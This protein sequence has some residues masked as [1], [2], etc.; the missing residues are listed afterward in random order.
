MPK[1]SDAETER[2]IRELKT[3]L[4]DACKQYLERP[5]NDAILRLRMIAEEL[6]KWLIL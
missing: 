3:E 1:V 6:L 5:D 4:I 2:V